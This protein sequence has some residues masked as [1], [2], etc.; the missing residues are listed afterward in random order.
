MAAPLTTRYYVARLSAAES[1]AIFAHINA[2]TGTDLGTL[3]QSALQDVC[4]DRLVRADG[5]LT[6]AKQLRKDMGEESLR[7]SVGRAYYSIHHSL[8][9]IALWENKWD[10]DGHAESIEQF[11]IL[12]KNADFQRRSELSE[13]DL[14]RVVQTRM[15]RH[16]ADYSPY[17]MQRSPHGDERIDDGD[18]EKAAQDNIDM[19]DRLFKAADRILGLY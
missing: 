3:F 6:L 13:D 4:L 12:L 2:F 16:V 9:C 11:K 19:A 18:W 15:N 14:D 8:R 17:D 1:R 10:P 7:A 5:C